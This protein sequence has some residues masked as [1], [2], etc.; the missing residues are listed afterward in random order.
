MAGQSAAF[1]WAPGHADLPINEAASAPANEP[2]LYGHTHL[3]F[4][5][6]DVYILSLARQMSLYTYLWAVTALASFYQEAVTHQLMSMDLFLARRPDT[7]LY[8]AICTSSSFM[9]RCV[10]TTL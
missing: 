9:Y 10:L 7:Y 5:G 4:L 2:D 6:S 1:C 3:T 8:T